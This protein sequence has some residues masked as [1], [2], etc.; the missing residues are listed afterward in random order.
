VI[1]TNAIVPPV[2]CTPW[3][4]DGTGH[5][6]VEEPAEQSCHGAEQRI[7]LAPAPA[8]LSS[9]V[10]S[11][12]VVQLYRDVYPGKGPAPTA[13][14]EPPHIEVYSS[15]TDVLAFSLTEAR[16]LGELLIQL[17]DTASV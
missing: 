15:G 4:T 11:H 9:Q 12:L 6:D 3:C 1:R 5:P 17:A 16:A 8:H 2:Q 13:T 10:R 14:V 7:E